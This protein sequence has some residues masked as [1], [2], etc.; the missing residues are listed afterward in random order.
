MIFTPTFTNISGPKSYLTVTND[1]ALCINH[2]LLLRTTKYLSPVA[3]CF[4]FLAFIH[5]EDS[6]VEQL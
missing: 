2:R 6:S 1:D 3:T 4:V 5:Q